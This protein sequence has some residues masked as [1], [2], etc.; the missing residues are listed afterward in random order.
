MYNDITC[1]FK[2]DHCHPPFKQVLT[3]NTLTFITFFYI[4]TYTQTF[5][6]SNYKC[7][8]KQKVAEQIN[9]TSLILFSLN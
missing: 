7:L 6:Y 4:D 9:Y 8:E 2:K 3:A 1:D 5:I